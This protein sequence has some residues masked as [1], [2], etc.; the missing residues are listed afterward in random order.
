[1]FGSNPKDVGPIPTA[2]AN[3]HMKQ[4]P[5]LDSSITKRFDNQVGIDLSQIPIGTRIEAQTKH[6][7]YKITVLRDGRFM[8]DGGFYFKQPTEA[9]ISGSTWGT[10]MLQSRWLG[11]G[12]NIEIQHPEEGRILTTP[13]KTLKVVASDESW[14]Y[15]LP[16]GL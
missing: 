12:M 3:K 14:E 15:T 9:G 10:E 1:M 13:V 11:I 2:S 6:S 8:I 7:L 4:H 5:N 16:E